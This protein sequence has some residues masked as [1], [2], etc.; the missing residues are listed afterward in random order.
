[1]ERLNRNIPQEL[2]HIKQLAQDCKTNISKDN[3]VAACDNVLKMC[4]DTFNGYCAE[5][6]ELHE[7]LRRNEELEEQGLLLKLPCEVGTTVYCIMT[8][9]KGTHPMIFTQRFNYNMI[10]CFGKA[11]FLTQAEAEEALKKIEREENQ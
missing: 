11:V 5:N 3:I 4:N 7:R 9:I 2:S 1:M 6:L 8:S 10:E